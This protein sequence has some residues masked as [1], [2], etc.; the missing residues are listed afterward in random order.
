M[1]NIYK[2]DVHKI[3][4]KELTINKDGIKILDYEKPVI[5]RDMQFYKGIMNTFI[6]FEHDTRLPDENEALDF[7]VESLKARKDKTA[8]YPECVFVDYDNM[9]YSHQICNEN[10]RAAKK[11]YKQMRKA[12]KR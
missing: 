1:K 8:P 5:R 4:V 6:S 12:K 7:I 3:V 11:Y 2:N 10:F 9:Q